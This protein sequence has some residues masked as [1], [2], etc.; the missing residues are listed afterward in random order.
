MRN[1][2]LLSRSHNLDLVG[3]FVDDIEDYEELVIDNVLEYIID[4]EEL[5]LISLNCYFSIIRLENSF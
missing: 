4:L 1:C 3:I 2:I 5:L